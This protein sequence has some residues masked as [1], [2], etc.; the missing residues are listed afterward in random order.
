MWQ[1]LAA[2][3]IGSLWLTA[4]TWFTIRAIHYASI[5]VDPIHALKFW[6]REH[7]PTAADLLK[8]KENDLHFN[9]WVNR[10]A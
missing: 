4:L 10:V 6:Y 2:F 3:S 1:T 7:K 5:K 9:E 8:Q